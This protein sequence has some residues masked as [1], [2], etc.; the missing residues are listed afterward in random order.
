MA[1][2]KKMNASRRNFLFG[3]VRRMKGEDAQEVP[4][5]ATS[6]TIPLLLEANDAF[7][8]EKYD[9]AVQKYREYL[10]LEKNDV[11]V[12]LQ[13]G[14]SLYRSGKFG[15]ARLEF[16]KVLKERKKDPRAT[17]YL[18]LTHARADNLAKAANAW[19][20]FFDLKNVNLLR[21]INVQKGLIQTGDAGT[22]AEVA[23]AVEAALKNA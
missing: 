15:A 13:L 12:H 20:D 8:A 14:I 9:D 17:V 19:D 2:K 7:A 23:E 16:R 22:G 4:M 21:E 5:A 3:A 18:G 6:E 1:D 11:D 10:K